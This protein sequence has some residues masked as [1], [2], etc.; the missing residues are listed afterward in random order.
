MQSLRE[1]IHSFGKL[2]W[3][4]VIDYIFGFVGVYQTVTG[5]TTLPQIGWAIVFILAFTIPPFIAFKKVRTKRDEYA[6]K[7]QSLLDIKPSIQVVPE[8]DGGGHY[9]RV[10]NIG[11][12]AEFRGKVEVMSG[13]KSI[14][15]LPTRYSAHWEST[16][17]E[18]TEIDKGDDD[19]LHIARLETNPIARD[20]V[21]EDALM[22]WR[23]YYYEIKGV[24]AIGSIGSIQNADSHSWFG[25]RKD[26][27]MP[28]IAL[29]VTITSH[30]SM[31]DS[32]TKIY[33]LTMDGLVEIS[34]A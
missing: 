13:S 26:V 32:F 1:F 30:P 15:L 4:V 20:D 19:R 2:W 5:T 12:R 27:P 3:V 28:D 34:S 14:P 33:Q 11:E 25:V 17:S 8:Q 24:D 9:L 31:K 6:T 21:V 23:L 16:K 29:K 18:T 22:N 10:Q 7:Y